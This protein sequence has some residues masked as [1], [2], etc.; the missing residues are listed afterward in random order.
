MKADNKQIKKNRSG[1]IRLILEIVLGIILSLSLY[2]FYNSQWL[3]DYNYERS[4]KSLDHLKKDYEIPPG[5]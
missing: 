1:V 4:I 2:F 3:S 5:Q